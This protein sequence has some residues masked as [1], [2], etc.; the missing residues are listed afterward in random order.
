MSS[1]STDSVSERQ[2]VWA[3]AKSGRSVP[4]SRL[5]A[6]RKDGLLPPL[7]STGVGAGRAYYWREPDILQQAELVHDGLT[8][9]GRADV[10]A[11]AL[12]LRG[13]SMALPKLKRAW[14][15]CLRMRKTPAIRRPPAGHGIKD[16]GTDDLSQLLQQVMLGTAA[17]VQLDDKSRPALILLAAA[18]NRL[19]IPP[20]DRAVQVRQFWQ[21]VQVL[22]SVLAASDVVSQASEEEMLKARDLLC[23][24]LDFI[25]MSSGEDAEIVT[26]VLGETLFLYVLTL[27]RSGQD[28]VLDQAAE[29]IAGAGRPSNVPSRPIYAQA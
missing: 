25:K 27:L 13:F 8:R 4:L 10:V 2:L 7:A 17:A 19:D 9:H 14:Q 6:W 18:A 1:R 15:S 20:G 11:V 12:W 22:A 28:K 5:A 23:S 26:E 3:L 24:A 21:M 29:R 16:T